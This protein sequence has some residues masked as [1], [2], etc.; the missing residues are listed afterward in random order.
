[1]ARVVLFLWGSSTSTSMSLAL[2][3]WQIP[4]EIRARK[5]SE[6]SS[7]SPRR[8]LAKAQ[9]VNHAILPKPDPSEL[10]T[11]NAARETSRNTIITHP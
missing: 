10:H 11:R 5:K 6:I 7:S 4:K 2:I 8:D 1:M 9:N 3:D